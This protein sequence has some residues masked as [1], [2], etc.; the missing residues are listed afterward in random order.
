MKLRRAERG[1]QE[2][3]AQ[4]TCARSSGFRRNSRGAAPRLPM[5]L[6]KP[7]VSLPDLSCREC[8]I[9]S[10]GHAQASFTALGAGKTLPL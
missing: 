8:S 6:L 4:P 2:Q 7:F 5:R 10:I 1:V 3:A 9:L